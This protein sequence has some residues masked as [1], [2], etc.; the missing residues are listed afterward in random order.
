MIAWM[1]LLWACG[2][3]APEVPA[4]PPEAEPAAAPPA[5]EAAPEPAP[6]AAPAGEVAPV[7]GTFQG[8]EQ[9]D[10]LHLAVVDD[11]GTAWDFWCLTEACDAVVGKPELVGKRVRVTWE[12]RRE[13]VPEAGADMDLQ[14]VTKVEPL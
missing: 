4:A 10:Y 6:A 2:G 5:A 3:Q 1:A 14:V 13:H 11:A 9:G 12:R 8:A 7:E